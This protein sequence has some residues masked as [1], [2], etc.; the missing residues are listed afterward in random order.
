M[1]VTRART[2]TSREPAVW[3]MYSNVAGTDCG[4]TV[5]TATS[6]GGMPPCGCEF[7]GSQP[8][9]S[10]ATAA[11]DNA[12][13]AAT[14]EFPIFIS[15][16]LLSVGVG[17]EPVF[18]SVDGRAPRV[19]LVVLARQR[20]D[21]ALYAV[22]ADFFGEDVAESCGEARAADLDVVHLPSRTGFLLLLFVGNRLGPRFPAF[23]SNGD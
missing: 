10:E 7:A 11:I 12:E 16:S 19:V 23:G 4:C 22:V 13:A 2:S 3:P 15:Y 18:S 14:Y 20:I 21:Q 17:V 5:T 6:G 1:P 9:R 8:E